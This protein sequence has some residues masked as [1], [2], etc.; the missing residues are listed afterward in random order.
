MTKKNPE[1][2]AAYNPGSHFAYVRCQDGGR[3]IAT[4]TLSGYMLGAERNQLEWALLFAAAPKMAEALRNAREFIE[5][6]DPP[7][8][9][10]LKEIG[11]ALAQA[12][13]A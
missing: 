12:G 13:E 3:E 1:L 2:Y 9:D 4:I 7:Q 10:L 6:F 5:N 11:D 8:P